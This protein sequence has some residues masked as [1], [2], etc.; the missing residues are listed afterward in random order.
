[1]PIWKE[2]EPLKAEAEI[3]RGVFEWHLERICAVPL[4][5]NSGSLRQPPR[6]LDDAWIDIDPHD[7][8]GRANET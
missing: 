6:N 3:K 4:H 7:F 1:M 8:S 2:L 5:W